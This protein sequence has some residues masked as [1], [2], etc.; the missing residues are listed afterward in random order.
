M[1]IE[2]IHPKYTKLVENLK[3]A[4]SIYHQILANDQIQDLEIYKRLYAKSDQALEQV[5]SVVKVDRSEFELS[6]AQNIKMEL[7]KIAIAIESLFVQFHHKE[8]LELCVDHEEKIL[9]FFKEVA[10]GVPMNYEEKSIIANW[11]TRTAKTLED[12]VRTQKSYKEV[13]IN[14]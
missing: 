1:T 3:I 9:L 13:L 10:E 11:L 14:S 12:L 2:T 7:E 6:V 4:K 5:T 8:I